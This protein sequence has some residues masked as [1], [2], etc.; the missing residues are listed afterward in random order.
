MAPPTL[1]RHHERNHPA[2]SL[3]QNAL[4]AIR[5]IIK[6]LDEQLA[7]ELP[8]QD[9]N[10]NVGVLVDYNVDAAPKIDESLRR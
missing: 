8:L 1:T 4:R 2:W 10:L 6:A 3:Q 9:E 7:I 5:E